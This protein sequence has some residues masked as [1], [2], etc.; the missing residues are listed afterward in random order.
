[1]RVASLLSG[2][3]GADLGWRLAG[4][5]IVSQ[6]E[7]DPWRRAVLAARFP[8]ATQARSVCQWPLTGHLPPDLLYIDL[9]RPLP[10]PLW[11][12]AAGAIGRACP[13]WVVVEHSVAHP[14]G[15]IVRDL[16]VAGYDIQV[17]T[18]FMKVQAD[19]LPAEAYDVRKRAFVL[20]GATSALGQLALKTALADLVARV[21]LTVPLGTVGCEEQSRG[22]PAGWTCLCAA[23]TSCRCDEA[24]RRR[25]I[26]EAT[27]PL[28]TRWLA[29]VFAGA[30]QAA[31]VVGAYRH[32]MER[33]CAPLG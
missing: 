30:W 10:S 6:A 3:G 23:G 13:P 20:A 16:V 18:V 15:P 12:E 32:E 28:L 2:I 33:A 17:M 11:A 27:S 26:R 14:F 7:S 29:D 31:E 22:F 25:A 8:E 21:S 19:G 1:M 24:A 9:P 5:R 4:H